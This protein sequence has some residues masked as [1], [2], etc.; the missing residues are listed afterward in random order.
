MTALLARPAAA[1]PRLR[2][3]R[4]RWAWGL[5]ALAAV[6]WSATG[7]LDGVNPAGAAQFGAFAA[8]ALSPALDGA[9][10]G[11]L[12]TAALVTVAYA[13]LGTA[14]AVLLGALGAVAAARST[15]GRRR[16]GRLATRGVLAVPR[17][18][19]EAVWGLLLVNVLGLDPWVGVLAIGLP[20]GAVTAT[21]FGALLDEVPRGPYEALRAA[22]AGRLAAAL[23][24]LLPRAA[25]GLLS[26]ACYRLECAVRS[27]VV[28]GL[29]GAGGLGYQL[30][31]SFGSLRWPQVWSA[32]YALALLCLA[33]DVAGRAVR[34]RL[35]APRR[36]AGVLSRD[37]VLTAAV[38][39]TLVAGAWSWWFL[40]LSPA[41]LVSARARE[42]AGFVLRAAWPPSA[43]GDLLRSVA[44][45]AVVTVQTSVLAVVLAA[46]GAVL[47]AGVAARPAGRCSPLRR[48]AGVLVRL[49]LLLLRAVPAPVWALVLLFV[50]LPGV[51]PGAVALGVYTLG[52]LGRLAAEAVEEADAGPRAALT[53]LGAHPA[54]GWLYGVAPLVAGPVLAYALYRWEVT[55][56][57]TLLVGLLGAG[58]LGA[59]LAS[60]LAA[61][62][63][64]AVATVLT[65][66][67]VLTL[68]VDLVGD[69]ARRAL[70]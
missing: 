32:V 60:E 4:R 33:A 15:W 8:A 29:V 18:L 65:A 51:L 53:A 23:Y 13:V 5:A 48:L 57:D 30:S 59:L 28:L 36:R 52:V 44:A 11:V 47:V 46:V 70:R 6:C 64:P 3:D 22:G 27:A 69:R 40:A 39:G 42:Q 20:Y 67:V 16:L 26:Y 54:G 10:L 1:V 63:W 49:G 50:L 7:A 9:F 58:G 37:R 34:R 56:R 68:A 2:R 31:L 66:T 62:D 19:H 55:V 12:A 14:L 43:D 24:G 35:A 17:G 25:G 21:V 41:S 38:L 61:F 45:A